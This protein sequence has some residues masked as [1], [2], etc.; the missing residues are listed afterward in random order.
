MAPDITLANIA[1]GEAVVAL[2][3]VTRGFIWLAK[4]KPLE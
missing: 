2:D 4:Y 3:P 1:M